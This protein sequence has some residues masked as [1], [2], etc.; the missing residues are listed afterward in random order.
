MGFKFTKK[1]GKHYIN[2]NLVTAKLYKTA[3]KKYLKLKPKK[4]KKWLSKKVGKLSQDPDKSNFTLEVRN[5]KY[6][7][8]G[9]EMPKEMAYKKLKLLL[10]KD[11]LEEEIED[12][13]V[14]TRVL[15]LFNLGADETLDRIDEYLDG[16]NISDGLKDS[17][18]FTIL[19]LNL[20]ANDYLEEI[21]SDFDFT[22]E[23]FVK[24]IIL[25]KNLSETPN[26]YLISIE[27]NTREKPLIKYDPKLKKLY[28][29]LGKLVIGLGMNKKVKD[30]SLLNKD[31][32]IY[33]N[34]ILS[35]TLDKVRL[36]TE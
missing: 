11:L 26:E 31:S 19:R 15:D 6:H 27:L 30:Y 2:G 16:L 4:F 1:S 20:K 24:E 33:Q 29:E 35:F 5:G 9:A 3:L 25:N 10:N 22:K 14:I 32:I 7:I 23:K 34:N 17:I 18:Y 12:E 8:D 36:L 21:L 28:L 13:E